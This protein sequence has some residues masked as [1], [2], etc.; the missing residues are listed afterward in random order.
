MYKFF[1]TVGYAGYFPIAPGTVGAIVGCVFYTLCSEYYYLLFAGNT[2]HYIFALAILLFF[3]IGVVSASK[4]EA[5]YGEDP[6]VVVI[7]ELV[8]VWIAL[9]LVPY[10]WPNLLLGFILFRIFD[11]FKPL[12]IRYLDKKVKGG[13]GIML[14]DV[15]AGI[16]ANIVL[17]LLRV[18]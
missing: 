8:G 3:A 6:S 2:G 18:F 13:W 5:E 11:I 1:A 9:F 7:D 12:G 15:L 14:D 10:T 17:Q 4:M 16:Y